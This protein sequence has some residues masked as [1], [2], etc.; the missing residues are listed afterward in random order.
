LYDV[1]TLTMP[2]L[3]N[4]HQQGEPNLPG[5]YFKYVRGGALVLVH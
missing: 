2:S 5:N 3:Q 1:H 4:E